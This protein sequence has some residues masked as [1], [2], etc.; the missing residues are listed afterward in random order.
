VCFVGVVMEFS[1]RWVVIVFLA[2]VLL[3]SFI[4]VD[5][6]FDDV[7]ITGNAVGIHSPY[8]CEELQLVMTWSDV[9]VESSSGAVFFVNDSGVDGS[10]SGFLGYKIDGNDVWGISYENKVGIYGEVTELYWS[11]YSRLLPE[12]VSNI[13]SISEFSDSN[14]AL[15]TS[16]LGDINTA[17]NRFISFDIDD[18]PTAFSSVYLVEDG[19]WDEKSDYFDFETHVSGPNIEGDNYG[20]VFSEVDSAS[21]SHISFDTSDYS[22]P[23]APVLV[24]NIS[25]FVFEQNSSWNFGF[26]FDNHFDY[27]SGAEFSVDFSGDI[28]NTGGE[29]INASIDGDEVLF[30]PA[31]EFLGQRMFSVWVSSPAGTATSNYFNVSIVENINDAPVLERNFGTLSLVMDDNLT[32]D[33]KSYFSDPD[34]DNL[35]YRTSVLENVVVGFSGD[36]MDVSLGENFSNY[37]RFRVYASD[38]EFE[39]SSNYVS[40][41]EGTANGSA[42]IAVNESPDTSIDGSDNAPD[43]ASVNEDQQGEDGGEGEGVGLWVW[44]TL[45]IV[46]FFV[47]LG[48]I[49]YFIFFSGGPVAPG[50]GVISAPVSPGGPSAP[51]NG[52]PAQPVSENPVNNYLN[53]LNLPKE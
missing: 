5:V 45:G 19:T 2:V 50:S 23:A 38:D 30:M 32:V 33:L 36:S 7:G 51:V 35:T 12:W 53:N 34:D 6:N 43:S 27:P 44:I 47:V 22:P 14:V 42:F 48:V 15:L 11:S 4:G 10:C 41:I 49:L 13:S 52:Q 9:F 26:S 20:L 29:W 18:I 24:T 40:V 37:E 21:Y 8:T 28:N 16:V 25:N 39:T 17:Q 1:K 31:D 3:V 46:G